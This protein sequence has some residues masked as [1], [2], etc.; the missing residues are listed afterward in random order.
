MKFIVY[1]VPKKGKYKNAIR[2]KRLINSS[3]SFE[4]SLFSFIIGVFIL[5]V[6]VQGALL[7]K[8][9]RA[10]LSLDQELEGDPLQAQEYLYKTGSVELE[11][12][13][14]FANPDVKVLI[15][16]EEAGVFNM[17]LIT[18]QVKDGDVVEIDGSA[19]PGPVEVIVGAKSDN[20]LTDCISTSITT[21]SDI[22]LL[23]SIKLK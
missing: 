12:K 18:L 6:I 13:S 4:R 20:I 10:S 23:T 5:L 22:R 16:G 19:V 9:V 2:E 14:G 21:E 1:K 15:N 7:T 3:F 8:S 11:L 17:D